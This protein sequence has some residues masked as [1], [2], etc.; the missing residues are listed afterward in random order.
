[1][2]DSR[3]E[4]QTKLK[5]A[6]HKPQSKSLVPCDGADK[7]MWA[8]QVFDGAGRVRLYVAE[9]RGVHSVSRGVASKQRNIQRALGPTTTQFPTPCKIH[10]HLKINRTAKGKNNQPVARN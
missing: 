9:N 10:D 3:T 8:N 2:C 6:A 7:N 1:M 4:T 5:N